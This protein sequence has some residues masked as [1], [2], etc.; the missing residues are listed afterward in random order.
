MGYDKERELR[1]AQLS[2]IGKILASFSH[3]MSNHL[4]IVRESTGVM[5]DLLSL[6]KKAKQ[7]PSQYVQ[8]LQSVEGQVEKALKS[9]TYFNRY[10]HRMDNEMSSFNL[11]ESLEEL[12]ALVTRLAYR[13]KIELQEDFDWNVPPIYSSP[14]K[15]HLLVF[16]IVEEKMKQLDKNSTLTVKTS[17][18]GD[19]VVISITP[20]GNSV[21]S[22]ET[23]TYSEELLQDVQRDLS[24]RVARK[25]QDGTVTISLPVSV[26]AKTG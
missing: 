24:A 16:W 5:Q 20:R 6:G 12:V 11:N 21:V 14:S 22:E 25:D 7:D 1:L 18:A 10:A 17:H 15:L 9:L 8:F 23:R 19:G 2:F 3:E 13:R 26:V 4:A